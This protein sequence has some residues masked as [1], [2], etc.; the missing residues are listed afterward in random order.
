MIIRLLTFIFK[1]VIGNL[2]E[3]KKQEFRDRFDVLLKDVV[4][5]ATEGAVKGSYPK[6]K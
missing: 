1:K 2:P 6:G 4:K 5:A 3:D